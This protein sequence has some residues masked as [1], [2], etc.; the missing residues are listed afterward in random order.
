M[1]I[2]VS[3]VRLKNRHAEVV[4]I[5]SNLPPNATTML[6]VRINLFFTQIL[7][8]LLL[9]NPKWFG[10]VVTRKESNAISLGDEEGEVVPSNVCAS[11]LYNTF[12]KAFSAVKNIHSN[13][14]RHQT[15]FQCFQ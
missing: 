10:N 15:L 1:K 5:L 11:V 2:I 7:P 8:S 12:S 6:L 4:G 9:L 14:V 13:T 3:S